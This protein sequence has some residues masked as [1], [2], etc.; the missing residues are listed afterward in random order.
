[1]RKILLLVAVAALIILG[2]LVFAQQPFMVKCCVRGECR[3]MT[4]PECPRV[5]GHIV[6]NCGQC[7]K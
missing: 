5:G 4:R 2:T 7:R 3:E 1:M 6:A